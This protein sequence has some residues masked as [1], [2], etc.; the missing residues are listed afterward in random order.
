MAID[1][2]KISKLAENHM[3]LGRVDRAIEEFLKLIEDRPDDHNLLNRVGDAYLQ[4]GK[5]PEALDLFK[6]AG[7]RLRARRVQRQGHAPSSRR[8]TGSRPRTWTS[9]SAWRNSTARPT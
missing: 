1:R 4:A 3:A 2:N 7:I 8:P 6:K 9:P 5:I